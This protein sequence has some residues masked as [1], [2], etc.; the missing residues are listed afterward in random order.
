M[1]RAFAAAILIH[2]LASCAGVSDAAWEKVKAELA[3]LRDQDQR[4]RMMMDS[5]AR[6]ES[7][8]SKAVEELW[9]KQRVLDSI[10]LAA[11]DQLISRYGYPPASRVGE[12]SRVPLD[13]IRHADE[14][15]RAD[16]V[17]LIIGAAKNGDLL[18]REAAAFQDEV[19]MNQRVPQEYGT[20]VWIESKENAKTGER[21]D[22]LF[23]WPIRDPANIDARRLSIGLDSLSHHLRRFGMEPGKNYVI[24]SYGTPSR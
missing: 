12:L 3:T 10:N 1:I 24:R 6:Q 5:I 23:L 9:E 4:Y 22:S 2:L 21:Y 14:G 13:V 15:V 18:M 7:W 8:Q 17:D 19:L 20:Q 11:I 16:Y